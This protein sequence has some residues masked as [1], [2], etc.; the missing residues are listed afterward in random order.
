M[1][2]HDSVRNPRLQS[3]RIKGPC[4]LI[5]ARSGLMECRVCGSRHCANLQSGYLRADGVT[6]YHRGSWQC[7]DG[8]C[9][10]NNKMWDEKKE[11]YVKPNWGELVEAATV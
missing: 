11:R 6:R 4:K 5:D 10:S 2:T 9:P 8:Q 1:P 7:I 3:G